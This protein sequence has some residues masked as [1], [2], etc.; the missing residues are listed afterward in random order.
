MRAGAEGATAL[1]AQKMAATRRAAHGFARS[2]DFKAGHDGFA[3]LMFRHKWK[4]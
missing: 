1:V 4:G 2:G 3:G